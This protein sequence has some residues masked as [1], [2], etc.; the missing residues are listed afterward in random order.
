MVVKNRSIQASPEQEQLD[1]ILSGTIFQG[2]EP[3]RRLLIYLSEKSISGEAKGLKEYT[4]GIEAFQKPETY[5]PRTDASVRIQAGRLRQKLAEYYHA[6]GKHDP[7]EIDFPKGHFELT[8]APR[9]IE[10]NQ[11]PSI[12]AAALRKWQRV[13]AIFAA[14]SVVLAIVVLAEQKT[15]HSPTQ[16]AYVEPLST[17]LAAFWSA[18]VE[19]SRPVLIALGTPLFAK[20]SSAFYRDPTMNNWDA[21]VSSGLLASVQAKLGADEASPAYIYTGLGEAT[22]A[23]E[24]GRLLVPRRTDVLLK[25]STVISWED[26]QN[27]NVIFLGSPKYNQQLTDLLANQQFVIGR[28]S[29]QNLRPR[30]NELQDYKSVW[31]GGHAEIVEDHAM[32]TRVP[33]LH[34]R[35]VITVLSARSTEGTLAAVQYVTQAVYARE[36]VAKLKTKG[37]AMPQSYQVIVRARFKQQ[38]PVSISY[39]THHE[40]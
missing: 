1:R 10:D 4:V 33:G 24:L 13:T 37:G 27:S 30:P 22:G 8:F 34:G 16:R 20:L 11:V 35:G 17:E 3:L 5:D 38:V 32:I 21:A 7:I 40:L 9:R 2:K 31:S 28:H 25:R 19:S 12:G 15:R 26:I 29:I 18:Y 23:F 39:A 14:L 6:E 36:L